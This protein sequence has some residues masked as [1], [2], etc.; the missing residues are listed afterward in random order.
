MQCELESRPGG[1]RKSIV[2]RDP[3]WSLSAYGRV[4]GMRTRARLRLIEWELLIVVV[5][6]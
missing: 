6:S 4:P 3:E 5:P 2:T 1:D